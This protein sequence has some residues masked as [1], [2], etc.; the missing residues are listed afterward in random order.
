MQIAK[1]KDKAKRGAVGARDARL[2]AS[3]YPA[4]W[5]GIGGARVWAFA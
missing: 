4:V 3:K 5:G 2:E 1:G